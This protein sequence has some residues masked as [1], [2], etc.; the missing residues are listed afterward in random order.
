MLMLLHHPM[1][2]QQHTSKLFWYWDED[3]PREEY[4]AAEM[5]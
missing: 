5:R 3:H 4:I 1:T 2:I